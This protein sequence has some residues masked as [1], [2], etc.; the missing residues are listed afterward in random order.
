VGEP[1]ICIRPSG[2]DA[3]QHLDCSRTM[4]GQ[5]WRIS[6]RRAHGTQGPGI[7]HLGRSAK[8]GRRFPAMF[9]AG[10]LAVPAAELGDVG[11]PPLIG[12][13][14]GEVT[15][16]QIRCGRRVRPAA[17][18]SWSAVHTNLAV[19]A[20]QAV[21]CAYGRPDA[22]GRGRL[23]RPTYAETRRGAPRSQRRPRAR[24]SPQTC[25]LKFMSLGLTG[26]CVDIAS[27][28]RRGILARSSVTS[29]DH[30]GRLT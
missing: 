1:V 7:D 8:R 21:P 6:D 23:G 20:H 2:S 18:P 30:H 28:E 11:D 25:S 27:C 12:P 13:L 9:E 5:E 3:L 10:S 15:F 22:P 17:P 19:G 24:E 16:E 26:S 4:A 14:G 29:A